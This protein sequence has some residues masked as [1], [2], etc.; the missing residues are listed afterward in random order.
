M[1]IKSRFVRVSFCLSFLILSIMVFILTRS[2]ET[3]SVFL[4][5]CSIIRKIKPIEKKLKKVQK[6]LKY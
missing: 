5:A 3:F 6:K 4:G 1:P 2:D